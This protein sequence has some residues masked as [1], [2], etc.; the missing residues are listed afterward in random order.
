MAKC[1]FCFPG[2]GPSCTTYSAH[3]HTPAR[4]S[5]LFCEKQLNMQDWQRGEKNAFM[6]SLLSL[7]GWGLLSF[8]CSDSIW[9]LAKARAQP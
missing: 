7:L 8:L 2:G 6:V 1:T 5:E 9:Q 4:T 3:G